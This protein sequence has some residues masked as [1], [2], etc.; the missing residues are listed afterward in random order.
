MTKPFMFLLA[1]AV[2]LGVSLGGAFAGGV[3]F[4]K[5]QGEETTANLGGGPT[6]GSPQQPMSQSGQGQAG[7]FQQGSHR[8]QFGREGANPSSGQTQTQRSRDGSGQGFSGRGGPAGTIE[9]IEGDTLTI[10]TPRG[11]VQATLKKDTAFGKL[12]EGTKDDLQV[13]TRVMVM[14]QRSEDGSV[15]A[16]SIIVTPEGVEGIFGRVES[17]DRGF[18]DGNEQP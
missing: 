6:L 11:P 3:A 5:S 12:S 18:R 16:N 8:D 13:G 14:G 15:E 17:H 7:R 10:T 9:K 4:G 2:V 1:L